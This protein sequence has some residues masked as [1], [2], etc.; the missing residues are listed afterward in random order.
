[1]KAALPSAALLA[2]AL[3][4]GCDRMLLPERQASYA[5]WEEGLTLGYENP[6][7]TGERRIQERY[8]VRVKEVRPSALGHTGTLTTATRTG[9]VDT[10][11]VE[12]DGGMTVGMD[13]VNRFRVLPEG[14]PDRTSR[15]EDR[16]VFHWVVGRAMVELP[17]LKLPEEARL[18]VWVESAPVS[19]Q[20]PHR[21]TLYLPGIGEAETLL[22]KD[23]RWVPVFRLVTRGF[24]D[25]PAPAK[26]SQ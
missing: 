1:M 2:L 3:C 18:G 7:L 14:F 12:R 26:D 19:G 20:G 6:G 24:T 4:L 10:L 21:R 16:G 13:P 9:Q 17:G 11:F 5:P 8:Q 15:W 23:G 25:G 22:R